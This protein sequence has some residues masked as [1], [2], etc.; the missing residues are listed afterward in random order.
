MFRQPYRQG[1]VLILPVQP[2]AAEGATKEIPREE[3]R[4]VLAHGEVTGHSHA[5]SADNA[6][7]VLNELTQKR[8][9]EVSQA[10]VALRHE[11]HAE[12]QLPAGTYEIR[13]QREYEPGGFRQV[14]D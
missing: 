6:R 9:L 7:F 1:D 10:P 8:F 13:I 3:G 5:I 2:Q 12:I 14:A 11:E 4:V